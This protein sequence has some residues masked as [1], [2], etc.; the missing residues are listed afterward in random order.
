MVYKCYSLFNS[1][2]RARLYSFP[3]VATIIAGC[4]FFILEV[5]LVSYGMWF[6]STHS[7]AHASLDLYSLSCLQC[8]M[9]YL[10]VFF[11]TKCYSLFIQNTIIKW[12]VSA[13]HLLV[14]SN[15]I[16]LDISNRSSSFIGYGFMSSSQGHNS[17]LDRYIFHHCISFFAFILLQTHTWVFLHQSCDSFVWA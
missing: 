16:K 6:F 15:Q 5:I 7:L 3:H 9:W 11:S 1:I 4:A 14:S 8:F 10:L 17:I 13:G 2:L 12:C